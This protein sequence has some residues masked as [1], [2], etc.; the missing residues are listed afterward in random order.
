MSDPDFA[1][2]GQAKN[3]A[4]I[5]QN[6]A[7]PR[8]LVAA[9]NDY[10]RGDGTC[11]AARSTNGGGSWQ[12]STVPTG[13]VRGLPTFGTARQYYQA[14]GDPSVAWDTKG[15]TY[16]SCQMFLRGNAT[17]PNPDQSSDLS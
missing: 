3:E 7:N 16:L 15:N 6:P 14:A 9:F 13:F 10:R 8:Q 11:G 1:G 2:R 5:A 4:F 17:A 12:D